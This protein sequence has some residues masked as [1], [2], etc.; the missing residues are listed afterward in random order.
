MRRPVDIDCMGGGGGRRREECVA[1]Q[2]VHWW[3]TAYMSSIR[4]IVSSVQNIVSSVRNI[5]SSI[6]NIM[7][8]IRNIMSSIQNIMSS[9]RNMSAAQSWRGQQ[10]SAVWQNLEGLLLVFQSTQV[11]RHLPLQGTRCT[12]P[13]AKQTSVSWHCYESCGD[14]RVSHTYTVFTIHSC[15]FFPWKLTLYTYS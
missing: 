1:I 13:W 9:I 15:F 6:R 2:L 10:Q 14:R 7:S 12:I 3:C 5:M 8:G 4:N 11:S